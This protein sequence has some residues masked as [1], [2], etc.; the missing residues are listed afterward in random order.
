MAQPGSPDVVGDASCCQQGIRGVAAVVE[1]DGRESGGFHQLPPVSGE[2]LRRDRLAHLVHDDV[3]GWLVGRTG[4]VFL[5]L[6]TQAQLGEPVEKLVRDGQGPVAPLGLGPLDVDLLPGA[7][8]RLVDGDDA[9]G[10]ID[11]IPS[12][13]EDLAPAQAVENQPPSPARRSLSA[14]AR[15]CLASSSDHTGRSAGT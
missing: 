8:A 3:A 7:D 12:E 10:E 4:V 14:C 11:V 5:D 13:T 15:N 9:V 2:R 6:L 1:P